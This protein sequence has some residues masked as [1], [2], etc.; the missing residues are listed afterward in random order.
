MMAIKL[1]SEQE[2]FM[3]I[4]ERWDGQVPKSYVQ[5]LFSRATIQALINKGLIKN[6]YSSMYYTDMLIID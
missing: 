6:Y 1:S 4:L 2:R 3:N 5:G